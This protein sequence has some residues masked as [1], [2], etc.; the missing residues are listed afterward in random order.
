MIW[1]RK[2]TSDESKADEIQKQS[3]DCE[4]NMHETQ[5]QERCGWPSF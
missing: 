1:F 4:E 5:S 2:K 3:E